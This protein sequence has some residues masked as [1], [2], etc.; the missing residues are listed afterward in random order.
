MSKRPSVTVVA[1][2]HN[3]AVRVGRLL[4][5]LRGQTLGVDNFDVIIVDDGS[6]DETPAVLAEAAARGDLR[7]TV[8]TQSDAQ[9]PAT[10]RNR[11]W[12]EA[13][14]ELIAFTDDDCRPEADWLEVLLASHTGR[15]DR[16]V[17]GQTLPDPDELGELGPFSKTLELTYQSP[18]FETCNILYPRALLERCGGFNED[19]PAP[20]GEDTDLGR[21]AT[22]LG[23]V[24]VFAPEAVVYHAVHPRT[25]KDTAKAALLATED[26]R[27]YK[28][29]PELRSVLVQGVFYQRSHP[30][31]FQALLGVGLAR[32]SPLALLFAVPYLL[33]VRA[34]L[35]AKRGSLVYV[36]A[37][38]GIDVIEVAAT[39][40]GAIRHRIFVA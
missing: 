29:T 1:A 18:H 28:V 24:A 38:V 22:S 13:Q 12:R 35:R 16:I 26:V 9:G 17:Q 31:L 19:F 39:V 7:M 5:A 11:G 14:T 33:N 30:L 25:F 3:R 23:A 27:A 37:Y 2:A 15:E 36:P 20:A 34:R 21:R 40:R 32:R 10:A 4:D 6:R 8:L